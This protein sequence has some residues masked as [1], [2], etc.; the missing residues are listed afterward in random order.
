MFFQ[1]VTLSEFTLIQLLESLSGIDGKSNL[2]QAGHLESTPSTICR[3]SS[4]FVD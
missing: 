2:Q 1:H 3:D 4:P